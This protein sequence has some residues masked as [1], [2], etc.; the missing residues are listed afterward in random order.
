MIVG[1]G[2]DLAQV[3][4]IER[5][6]ALYGPRFARRVLAGDELEAFAATRNPV[7]FLALRFAAKEAASKALGTG[8]RQ[9]VALRQIAVWHE[10]SGKPHLRLQGAAA[11]RAAALGVRAMH[12]SLT[13][14][15]DYA[16]AV[17]VF[18][19]A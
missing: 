10:P 2:V 13:D 8:F 9:G 6:Y 16:A 11:A 15:R 14:E 19:S 5:V 18:E 4:R 1:L 17:V 12:I 3:E 7:R